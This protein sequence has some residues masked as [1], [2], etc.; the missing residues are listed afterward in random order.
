MTSA[1]TQNVKLSIFVSY[2]REDRKIVEGLRKPFAP[3]ERKFGC[4]LIWD[5]SR[6]SAGDPWR[7]QINCSLM[8]A[9]IAILLVSQDFLAS[10]FIQ[11]SELPILL[12]RYREGDLE[13]IP[14]LVG[15]VDIEET[16]LAD[17]Q[18]LNP[19]ELP[20]K[21]LSEYDQETWYLELAKRV[22]QILL[23]PS[24]GIDTSVS[25]TPWRPGDHQAQ[26]TQVLTHDW[27][28]TVPPV[29]AMDE[30]SHQLH[31]IFTQTQFRGFV[32]FRRPPYYVQFAFY[33]EL[34]ESSI[35]VE[36]VSNTHLPSDRP[37]SRL[38]IRHLLEEL[39]FTQPSDEANLIMV[40]PFG[41]QEDV[42]NLAKLT[43]H[44]LD[45]IFNCPVNL[46]LEVSGQ[47]C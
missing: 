3:L 18:F 17:L 47:C 13:L 27:K 1:Q 6:L 11:E 19:P 41:S 33:R 35:V 9:R 23:T 15:P 25:K 37:L 32:V 16:G 38:Q 21:K 24:V 45:K 12:V 8:E 28:A 22:K 10:T 29:L 2:A 43:W 42:A 5:D 46:S 14:V 36:V 30:I 31:R 20:L 39:E 34:D 7:T 26:R 44:V 4:E 40:A